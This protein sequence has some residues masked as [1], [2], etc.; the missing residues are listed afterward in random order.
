MLGAEIIQS[1]NARSFTVDE[2]KSIQ[3]LIHYQ[4]HKTALQPDVIEHA[5]ACFL[6]VNDLD[7]LKASQYEAAIRF[8][9]DFSGVN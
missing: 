7:Q 8:L 5:A 1:G 6:N 9:V 4:A 2:R 3:A